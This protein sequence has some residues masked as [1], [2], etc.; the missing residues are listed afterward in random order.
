MTKNFDMAFIYKD[1]NTFKRVSAIPMEFLDTI[2]SWL[3]T[4]NIL[5]SEGPMC[6]NWPNILN[7]IKEDFEVFVQDG[8][9]SFLRDNQSSD[10]QVTGEQD[11]DGSDSDF[12][13]D[14]EAEG[15]GS[16]AGGSDDSDFSGDDDE[17]SDAQSSDV[18]PDED[19][20]EEE[21]MDWDEMDKQAIEQE[22]R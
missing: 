2:K 20:E 7:H 13:E 8:G 18:Q 11:S 21:G 17:D 6:L 10:E 14:E 5:F 3:D 16:A 12:N 4:T 22:K 1:Y 15:D 19:E 9:W